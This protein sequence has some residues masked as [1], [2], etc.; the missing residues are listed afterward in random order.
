MV[1]FSNEHFCSP[2]RLKAQKMWYQKEIAVCWVY[3]YFQ[4]ADCQNT[5]PHSGAHQDSRMVT[6]IKRKLRFSLCSVFGDITK[7]KIILKFDLYLRWRGFCNNHF[8]MRRI[9]AFSQEERAKCHDDVGIDYQCIAVD[10]KS[11]FWARCLKWFRYHLCWIVF[12]IL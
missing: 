6:E 1:I 9:L 7:L 4:V 10:C 8:L 5:R 12:M 3:P 2:G 11:H